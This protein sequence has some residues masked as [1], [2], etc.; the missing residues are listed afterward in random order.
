MANHQFHAHGKVLITGEYAVLDGAQAL[1]LPTCLGQSLT[2]CDGPQSASTPYL[3][4]RAYDQAQHLWLEASFD[5][6]TLS[7]S[8]P[9]AADLQHILQQARKL[10]P[11]FLKLDQAIEATSHLEFDRNW[12]LGSSSTLIAL[13]AQWA[14]VDAQA[15]LRGSLG[16]SGYDVA[17]ATARGPILYQNGVAQETA[18]DPDFRDHL[19]FLHLNQKQD[20]RAAIAY[21]RS[22][23]KLTGFV[24]DQLSALTQA[25]LS[26]RELDAFETVLRDHEAAL[27]SAINLPQLQDTTFPDYWG[28]VKSLGAWGGDFA[29]VTS[30]A[31]AQQTMDYFNKRGYNTMMR[32]DDLIVR[33][34]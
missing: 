28:V 7:S 32:Y 25:A 34:Q 33:G 17:C 29:L 23:P 13:I 24:V 4:W 3:H 30:R 19:Y 31:D 12:G 11:Q 1:A 21:Y 14:S 5:L 8:T 2:L 6:T 10:N 26:A 22:Q 9:D 16:G 20:T 15:L 18:F 27:S